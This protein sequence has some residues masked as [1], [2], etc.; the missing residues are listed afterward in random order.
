MKLFTLLE[1]LELIK[2][3]IEAGSDKEAIKIIAKRLGDPRSFLY[4]M[5]VKHKR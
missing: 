2:E 1:E 4:L 3:H 5:G